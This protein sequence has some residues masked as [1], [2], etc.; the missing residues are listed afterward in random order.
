MIAYIYDMLRD[1]HVCPRNSN[2][3]L[4]QAAEIGMKFYVHRGT[5]ASSLT[6]YMLIIRYLVKHPV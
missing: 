1:L 3:S 4:L 5:G 6:Y 2:E